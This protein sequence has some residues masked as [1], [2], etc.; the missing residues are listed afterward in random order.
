MAVVIVHVGDWPTRAGLACPSSTRMHLHRVQGFVQEE[1]ALSSSS[2][3]RARC[4]VCLS[5]TLSP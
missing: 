2:G 3:R 5:A 4:S 1:A